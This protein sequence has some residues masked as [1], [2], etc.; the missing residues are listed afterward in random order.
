MS[1]SEQAECHFCLNTYDYNLHFSLT[2]T[3]LGVFLSRQVR[4]RMIKSFSRYP[5]RASY[6]QTRSL[7][8]NQ[9]QAVYT[10]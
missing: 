8:L 1:I 3:I 10:L 4:Y 9:I 6:I 5:E 2:D 7:C